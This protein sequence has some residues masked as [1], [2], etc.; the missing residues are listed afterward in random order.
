[1]AIYALINSYNIDEIGMKFFQD[2]L[3]KNDRKTIPYELKK[4]YGTNI[5]IMKWME[6]VMFVIKK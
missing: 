3:I 5:I 2:I 4:K 6:N 1:M